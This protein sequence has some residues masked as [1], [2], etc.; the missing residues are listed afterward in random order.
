MIKM[1][2]LG[3][4]GEGVGPSCLL[5]EPF[6]CETKFYCSMFRLMYR[7]PPSHLQAILHDSFPLVPCQPDDGSLYPSLNNFQ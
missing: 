1:Y 6:L 7:E 4:R 3:G 2:N 5:Q